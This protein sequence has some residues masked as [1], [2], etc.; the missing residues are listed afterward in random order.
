MGS[1]SKPVAPLAPPALRSDAELDPVDQLLEHSILEL[2]GI[3]LQPDPPAPDRATPRFAA[4]SGSHAQPNVDPFANINAC[5]TEHIARLANILE[6]RGAQPWQTRMRAECF[7]AAGLAEGMSVLEI[8]CGT[9][10]V[11][12]ELARLTGPTGR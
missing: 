2:T 3:G 11:A 7:R 1:S 12:R 5:T 8:G 6:I 4:H 9:G 10:V